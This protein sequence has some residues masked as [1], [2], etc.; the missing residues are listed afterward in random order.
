MKRVFGQ[1]ANVSQTI[2]GSILPAGAG[3]RVTIEVRAGKRW[4]RLAIV[5]LGRDGSYAARV[6]SAGEY[7]VV[8]RGLEGPSVVVP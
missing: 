8:Y 3:E 4:H 7:R 5:R 6:A 1:M 2:H